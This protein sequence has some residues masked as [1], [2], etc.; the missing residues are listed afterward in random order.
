MSIL[1]GTILVV[2]SGIVAF[3]AT[4]PINL[5]IQ[6]TEWPKVIATIIRAAVREDTDSEGTAHRPEFT[7]RYS[8]GGNE[9]TSSRHTEGMPFNHTKAAALELVARFPVNGE[10][11]VAVKP[12]EPAFAVL[13]TGIP[14]QWV[15]IR[16]ACVG[17]LLIGVGIILWNVLKAH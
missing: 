4:R 12:N 16:R 15:I 13:D 1:F 9:Y 17:L 8:M 14:R 2:S 10:V 6:S 7:F 3:R 5:Y 11:M